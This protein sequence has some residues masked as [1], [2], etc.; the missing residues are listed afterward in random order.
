MRTKFNTSI[1]SEILQKFKDKCKEDKLPVSV[2]LERFMKGYIED[3]FV[4]GMMWSDNNGIL[5]S[6]AYTLRKFRYTQ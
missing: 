4:L 2:V 3:K 6:A 5:K 1:D